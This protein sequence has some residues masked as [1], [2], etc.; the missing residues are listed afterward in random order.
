MAKT[1]TQID[2]DHI[3]QTELLPEDREVL[4]EDKRRWTE[5]GSGAHLT[6]WLQFAAGLRI[7]R[8]LAMKV[9]FT[10]QPQGRGYTQTYGQL[11]RFAGFDISDKRLMG[12]LTAV[13]WLDD[14]PER[15][16]LLRDITDA[17]TP[18]ERSRLNSPISA[19]QRVEK[20]LKAREGGKEA[21]TKDAPI[22]ILKAK[23]AEQARTIAH[24]EEKLAA[25]Q[26]DAEDGSLFGPKDSAARV[27][28][29]LASMN[30]SVSKIDEICKLAKAKA[31]EKGPPPPPKPK[32]TK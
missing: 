23:N 32:K 3:L 17:M 9:N 18:G 20:I 22:T 4:A 28:D 21:M 10:N 26:H 19:R 6:Q 8:R 15:L 13:A 2:I 30:Y 1:T 29:V 11:L 31:R 12:T 24:L 7:R 27:A 25:A 16:S 14:K 5:L